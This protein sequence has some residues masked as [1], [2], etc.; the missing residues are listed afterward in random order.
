MA[1]VVVVLAQEGVCLYDTTI[2]AK[3]VLISD[4]DQNQMFNFEEFLR[5][6]TALKVAKDLENQYKDQPSIKIHV[7]S[8]IAS[9]RDYDGRISV[10]EL[11]EAYSRANDDIDHLRL[12]KI[13]REMNVENM[14][15]YQYAAVCGKLDLK[16]AMK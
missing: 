10:D 7:A 13:L 9:D 4:R 16:F 3:V 11:V 2:M 14:D 1:E 6:V 12:E 8:Y 15:I 5:I